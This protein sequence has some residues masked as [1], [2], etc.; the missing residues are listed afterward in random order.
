MMAISGAMSD[1]LP[2]EINLVRTKKMHVPGNHI[3]LSLTIYWCLQSSLM[4]F[5][6]KLMYI[7]R[8]PH[9]WT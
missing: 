3:V 5:V 1:L 4:V 6:E 7:L 2:T 8:D 9:F